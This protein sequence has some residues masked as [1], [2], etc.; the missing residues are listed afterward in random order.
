MTPTKPGFY[1]AKFQGT[2]NWII[3]QVLN[4][5]MGTSGPTNL[6]VMITG[7]VGLQ[8]LDNFIWG[9]LVVPPIA[10]NRTAP[11]KDGS[12]RKAH[13]GDGVQ[14]WDTTVASGWG[15]HA[16]AFCVLRYLRRDKAKEHSIES[17]RWY[18]TRLIEFVAEENKE[19]G[20]ADTTFARLEMILTVEELIL[21]RGVDQ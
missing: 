12:V 2:E 10:A 6:K 20:P 5:V 15:P 14:P 16:A 9:S 17:A 1:W 8:R 7:S 11:G 4:Y 13:Y 21:V 18:Y 3:V 19:G